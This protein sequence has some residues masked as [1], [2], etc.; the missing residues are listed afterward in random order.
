[1]K[2]YIF[3]SVVLISTLLLGA[4]SKDDDPKQ[5]D[6]NV[7]H[8]GEKWNI[9]SATYNIVDQKFDPVS[10]NLKIGSKNNIGAFYFDGTN[11]SFEF[12]IDNI[13]KEDIFTFTDNSG[14]V[15]I[16]NVTQSIGTGSISQYVIALHGDK[17]SLTTMT[18]SGTI[19]RQTTTSQFTM[20]GTF[21]L[22][23]Q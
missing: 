2:K 16:V 19:T 18:L 3:S 6:P 13:H 22:T 11:G 10:Q 23:R 21:N 4:C 17:T 1:M 14:D 20:T 15:T 7:N 5:E 9:T 12:D 8:V